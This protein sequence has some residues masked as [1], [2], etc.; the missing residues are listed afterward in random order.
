MGTGLVAACLAVFGPTLQGFAASTF[1]LA[2]VVVTAT[3]LE[4]RLIPDRIVGPAVVIVLLTMT[5]A[6]PSLEWVL[7]GLCAAAFLLV[8]SL[9]S[10]QGMGM[11]DV[12]LAFLMGVA[13]GRDVGI[14]FVVATLLALIPSIAILVRHGSKGR[15]VGF[16]FGPFL[17]VGSIVALFL[18]AS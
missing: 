9:I 13:L 7:S 12:K 14:A 6:Q 4:Y 8:F 17:A 2:L 10:P 1:C 3:D 16:P 5:L 11:G 15:K 18:G